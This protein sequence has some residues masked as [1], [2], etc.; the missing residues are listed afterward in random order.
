MDIFGCTHHPPKGQTVVPLIPVTPD[1][2]TDLVQLSESQRHWIARLGFHA[3]LGKTCVVPG[4]RGSID[5]VLFGWKPDARP[6]DFAQVV[7][8]LPHGLY[9]GCVVTLIPAIALHKNP[10]RHW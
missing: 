7:S 2:L 5:C 3:D 10:C 6:D 8:A 1:S 9:R 4:E